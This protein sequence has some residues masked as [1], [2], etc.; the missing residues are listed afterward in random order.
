VLLGALADEVGLHRAHLM[1]PG[2]VALALI[3]FAVAQALERNAIAAA[4]CP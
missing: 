3:C 1:V 2:L 4:R